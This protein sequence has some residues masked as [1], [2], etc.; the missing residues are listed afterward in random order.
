ME[1][2]SRK[3]RRAIQAARDRARRE[4]E[5]PVDFACCGGCDHLIR[6]YLGEEAQALAGPRCGW[7]SHKMGGS[8]AWRAL[9]NA[10]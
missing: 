3:D 5:Q 6:V 2:L 7:S 1:H 10:R 8:W 9:E 4:R